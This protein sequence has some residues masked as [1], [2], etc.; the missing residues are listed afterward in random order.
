MWM[1]GNLGTVKQRGRVHRSLFYNMFC[2]LDDVHS[3][4]CNNQSHRIFLKFL[5]EKKAKLSVTY[6][7]P[8]NAKPH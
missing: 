1:H 2:A 8:L 6:M 3:N 7:H 4:A 5:W